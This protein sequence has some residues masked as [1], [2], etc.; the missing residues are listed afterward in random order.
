MAAVAC[1]TR[2]TSIDQIVLSSIITEILKTT[3][4]PGAQADK[5]T[6]NTLKGLDLPLLLV[7]ESKA[8]SQS[9]PSLPSF[10]A[11]ISQ[12]AATLHS[13]EFFVLRTSDLSLT[14]EL[15]AQ[16]QSP[17]I[18]VLNALDEATPVYEGKYEV[19]AILSFAKKTAGP[20]IS[21]LDFNAYVQLTQSNSPLAFLLASTQSERTALA[22]L[23]WPLA[24]KYKHR[25]NF[26]TVDT[27]KLPF[28]LEPLGVDAVKLPAFAI[29][30]GD[31]EDVYVY[32]QK[33]KV[34]AHDVEFFIRRSLKL[35]ETPGGK[36][37]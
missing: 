30:A 20:L 21:R 9:Q 31:N 5:Q 1:S 12:V 7:A 11:V 23:L 32:D 24:L 35:D 14:G 15:G 2:S 27:E 16:L 28:L 10:D 6:F 17:F 3:L 18:L 13:N 19:G 4:P 34:N 33:R 29:H 25:L 8:E 37:L 26:V 22:T 36:E